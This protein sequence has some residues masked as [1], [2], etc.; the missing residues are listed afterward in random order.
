[1]VAGSTGSEA[2]GTRDARFD[3]LYRAHY[4]RVLAYALRRTTLE[5]AHDVVA[6]T[7]L[8]AWRRL[9][10]VPDDPLP[11]LLGVA[12]KTLA[13]YRRSAERHNSLLAELTASDIVRLRLC[14]V[15]A[16][17][18]DSRRVA[19][20]YDRLSERDREVLRLVVWDGLP[21]SEAAAVLGVSEVACRVRYHRAKRHLAAEL[22]EAHRGGSA[23]G[24][25]IRTLS[26]PTS[27][28]TSL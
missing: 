17:D 6:D 27:G 26:N 19:E 10:R 23:I 12:R 13:N 25:S 8:V 7:F 2:S 16:D 15:A 20:A 18:A 1:M 5:L 3:A 28:R 14:S 9:D 21:P 22:S 24:R 11:W 4:S